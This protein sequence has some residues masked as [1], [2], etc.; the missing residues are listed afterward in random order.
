MGYPDLLDLQYTSNTIPGSIS[1][2]HENTTSTFTD[3]EHSQGFRAAITRKRRSLF[4][5]RPDSV[6]SFTD[7]TTKKLPQSLSAVKPTEPVQGV[8]YHNLPDSRPK[9][10]GRRSTDP[11]EN[12]RS[13]FGGRFKLGQK[14]E[15]VPLPVKEEERPAVIEHQQTRP[16]HVRG[17]SAP[18]DILVE[19]KNQRHPTEDE[20]M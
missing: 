3:D 9:T 14:K 8:L 7:L 11:T 12:R 17:I 20:C 10:G 5:G 15:T 4:G 2:A 6:T 18:A 13:F 19:Q 1:D 16:Q